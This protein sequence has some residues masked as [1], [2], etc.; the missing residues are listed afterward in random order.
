MKANTT[1]RE[2]KIELWEGGFY[3]IIDA[4]T[5]EEIDGDKRKYVVKCMCKRW[6]FKIIS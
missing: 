5:G 3:W 1:K 6:G 4:K 2:V